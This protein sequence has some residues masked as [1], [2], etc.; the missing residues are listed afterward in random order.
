MT[1]Q[2]ALDVLIFG[3]GVAG[4]WAL[5]ELV[6]SGRSA[7]LLETVALGSKQTVASQGIIHGG[8]KY[9]FDIKLASPAKVIAQMPEIWRECLTGQR[10]PDLRGTTVRSDCQYIWGTGSLKSRFFLQG[11]VLA[12]RAAPEPI[13]KS[14]A[15]PALAHIPGKIFRL[16]E[17]VLDTVSLVEHLAALHQG[18]ILHINPDVEFHDDLVRIRPAGGDGQTFTLQ[19]ASVVFSAGEGNAAL[20][21]KVGLSP[22]AMQRRPLRMVML[23][24]NLPKLYGHCVGGP[25]PRVTI[26]T[27]TDSRNRNVWQIGGQIAEDAVRMDPEQ[28]RR[29]ARDEIR[30]AL[31][32]IDLAGVEFASYCVDRAEAATSTGQIPDDVHVLADGRY[33]TAFPTKLALAPR[34][35]QRLCEM[36]APPKI[37]GGDWKQILGSFFPAPSIAPPPWEAITDWKGLD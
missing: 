31:P 30:A 27:S 17:Q 9:L 7:L 19:P 34:L 29:H 11:S 28:L 23:R 32:G 20:R 37:A 5:D 3:G 2:I 35:A 33:F 16:P 4:L 25:K 26:T 14:D 18:K 22:S 36:V 13:E 15:P 10:A 1:Q 21:E 8:L 24:G 6:R 12:L